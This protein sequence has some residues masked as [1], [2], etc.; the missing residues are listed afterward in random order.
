M[1]VEGICN[2]KALVTSTCPANMD[3]LCEDTGDHFEFANGFACESLQHYVRA[4]RALAADDDLVRRMQKNSHRYANEAYHISRIA[5]QW[6]R[7][8][9]VE[10]PKQRRVHRPRFGLA[11]RS[12]HE[13]RK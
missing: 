5:E 3:C 6:R 10:H 7:L 8:Y 2:G 4:I 11:R 12:L 1:L 9:I 13:V